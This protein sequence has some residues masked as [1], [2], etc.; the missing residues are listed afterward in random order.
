MNFEYIGIGKKNSTFE[1][2]PAIELATNV[3]TDWMPNTPNSLSSAFSE[4]LQNIIKSET[5]P[6]NSQQR[7]VVQQPVG[8]FEKQWKQ[9]TSWILG[10]AFCR[11]IMELEGYPFWAPVSAF[12]PAK[13][14][15]E[16]AAPYW[17]KFLDVNKCKIEPSSSAKFN[18][19]PDYVLGRINSSTDEPEISFAESKGTG[20]AIR[21]FTNL[22]KSLV[23]WKKQAKNAEF[24][25]SG[26]T[27]PTAQNLV[28]A[29]RF[30]PKK[31]GRQKTRQIL[32][33]AW[34]SYDPKA[35]VS[36]AAFQTILIMHYYGVCQRIGLETNAE[37]LALNSLINA[38]N[39]LAEQDKTLSPQQ[40][41]QVD[42]IPKLNEAYKQLT[43]RAHR[44]V[45]S[46]GSQYKND[47]D[48]Y[49][50]K[51][52]SPF[53]LGNQTMRI[54][55]DK[56]GFDTIQWL[57]GLNNKFSMDFLP[58]GK[59]TLSYDPK[60]GRENQFYRRSDG[61]TSTLI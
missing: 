58:K 26:T 11:R 40:K 23:Q 60:P 28:V 46:I 37:L 41:K 61:V 22:T 2:A 39:N 6:G 51:D 38:L 17:E 20:E 33:R 24:S 12:T 43:D 13:Y 55:L 44:E 52:R 29:T 53:T 19:L 42:S 25:I 16:T 15:T 3:I 48:I 7:W 59:A 50:N 9:T 10:V 8:L 54:G 47:T 27:E 31:N 5:L 49:I 45:Q 14:K 18:L 35:K 56:K 32:V 57:Q 34:D 30:Y 1:T 36:V 21:N 4:L